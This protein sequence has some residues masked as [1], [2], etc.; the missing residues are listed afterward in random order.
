[1]VAKI[2]ITGIMKKII[3][4]FLS[5]CL[6]ESMCLAVSVVVNHIVD[7]D[8]F[9]GDVILDNGTKVKSVSVRLRNVDTPEIHGECDS[10]I[11]MANRAKQRLSELIPTGSNIEIKNIKNDKY[12]GRIDANVFDSRGRDIGVILIHEK[13]GRPYSGG[14]RLSWCNNK[15]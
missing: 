2:T 10:E 4:A 9:T 6:T 14:K 3:F 5:F 8:T 1:M 13:L 11:M 12:F 15:K 7:G